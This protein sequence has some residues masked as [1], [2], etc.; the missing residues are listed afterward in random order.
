MKWSDKR[1][2]GKGYHSEVETSFQGNSHTLELERPDNGSAHR[3][4]EERMPNETRQ[5]NCDRS[6][7]TRQ[8]NANTFAYIQQFSST[9]SWCIN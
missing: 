7:Q 1:L 5:S 2:E 3:G 6:K 4:L 8:V 9:E